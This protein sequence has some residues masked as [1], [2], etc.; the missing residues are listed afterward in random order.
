[1][2]ISQNIAYSLVSAY[3]LILL[4][5]L[6]MNKIKSY[7]RR[8]IVVSNIILLCITFNFITNFYSTTFKFIKKKIEVLSCYLL[9]S[10]INPYICINI[11]YDQ[12]SREKGKYLNVINVYHGPRYK[13][14]PKH[15]RNTWDISVLYSSSHNLIWFWASQ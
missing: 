1:M 15:H 13:R 10:F 8:S 6:D 12:I 9:T 3:T 2:A 7:F 14:S 4:T 5:W 11:I